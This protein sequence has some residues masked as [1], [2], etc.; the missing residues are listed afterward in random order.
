MPITLQGPS[1]PAPIE[2]PSDLDWPDELNYTLREQTHSWSITN[3]AAL[4]VESGKK[5][6]GRPVTLATASM[7]AGTAGWLVYADP[8][9]PAR[10]TITT[11]RALWD[12]APADMTLV[13]DPSGPDEE[14]HAVRWNRAQP[15]MGF[16]WSALTP[17]YAYSDL[18][19]GTP[20]RATLHLYTVPSGA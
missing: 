9:D 14:T 10:A 1:W 12:R 20:C 13:L 16:E 4:V 7:G 5:A 17:D 19:A 11:L 3:P 2:L 6:H 15:G 18:P 8:A